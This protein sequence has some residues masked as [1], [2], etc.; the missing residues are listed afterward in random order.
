MRQ[1]NKLWTVLLGSM[2][3]LISC[4]RMEDISFSDN[5]D[6]TLECA[7]SAWAQESRTVIDDEGNGNFEEGDRI[8]V[9]MQAGEETSNVGLQYEN[10]KWT[11]SLK[12]VNN[13][14]GACTLSALYP[15]LSRPVGDATRRIL[16]LP[17]NQSTAA[18]QQEADILFAQT[19][20]GAGDASAKL[21]FKHALH[22]INIHLKGTVPED[23]E[24]RVRSC[25][26]GEISLVDG[27]VYLPKKS[28]YWITPRQTAEHTYSAIILPQEASDYQTGE[29]LLRLT[30]GGKEVSYSLTTEVLS[31]QPG[32]QTTLNLTLKS[33]DADVDDEVVDTE[34]AN[35][36]R[37]VCGI[38]SPVFP[39]RD[40]VQTIPVTTWITD[41]PVGKW[42]RNGYAADILNEVEYLTWK[43]GCGWYD[44]NKTFEYKG[45]DG[46]MCW[47]ATASNLLHWWLHHNR[48]Y[49]QA[50]EKA[51]PGN[52]CPKEYRQMTEKD[53]NH[54]DIFNFFKKNFPNLGSWETGGV[55]W[56]INGDGQKLNAN[57]NKDFKGFFNEVFS[58]DNAVATD[59]YNMSK[60]NFNRWMKEAFRMNKAIGFSVFGFANAGSGMHAMTIWGAEFD[61]NGNVA[62][63]YFCDNNQSESD[64]NYGAIKRYKVV[65]ELGKTSYDK[66][67]ETFLAPLDNIEGT[68]S[69]WRSMICS[70]TLVDLRQDIWQKA[71][72]GI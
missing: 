5:E 20:V 69:K 41:Y 34:F 16:N 67:R 37:W 23:L 2:W 24:L 53:Q 54:S 22:R 63:L 55:N 62:Y 11:P 38:T 35:Q 6:F 45:G 59:T 27:R 29:G 44:C 9:W 43:E 68:P 7:K 49:V 52:P 13:G 33:A 19:T 26:N 39:G 40:K 18:N 15:V 31:F 12:R 3:F 51:H 56:F 1:L 72:P 14:Q 48:K 47:A 71:F 8:D 64:P 36:T 58:K 57:S 10:G 50:Y 4:D 60:E 30:F 32:M 42:F 61:A 17:L 46:N 28:Y 70:L 65:Y 25:T 66:T 21:W